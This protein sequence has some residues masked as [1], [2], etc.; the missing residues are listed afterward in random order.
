MKIVVST[1]GILNF[2]KHEDVLAHLVKCGWDFATLG[3]DNQ[4]KSNK[5]AFIVINNEG[6]L[7]TKMVNG[8]N[9]EFI[10]R[11]NLDFIKMVEDNLFPNFT[12]KLDIIF[13]PDGYNYF[14]DFSNNSERIVLCDSAE[15]IYNMNNVEWEE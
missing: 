5:R 8:V 10:L 6:H 7:V 1:K 3:E 15:L 9:L 11:T 13:A 2:N 14:I 4:T 12:E